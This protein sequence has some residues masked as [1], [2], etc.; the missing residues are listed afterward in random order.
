MDIRGAALRLAALVLLLAAIP[1]GAPL[2]GGTLAAAELVTLDLD[3][4]VPPP[5]L[6][7]VITRAQVRVLA[8]ELPEWSGPAGV[9][10]RFLLLSAPF[11]GLAEA[12]LQ[13]DPQLTADLVTEDRIVDLPVWVVTFEGGAPGSP[14][15]QQQ[16]EVLD[17]YSGDR[18]LGFASP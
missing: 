3:F 7:P 8:R 13:G 14:R 18:L 10:Y 1:G 15:D 4:A 16:V 9:R 17:A 12:T 2:P 6:R 5:S 11:G